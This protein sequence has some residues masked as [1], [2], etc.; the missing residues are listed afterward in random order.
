MAA[1]SCSYDVFLSFR[2]SDTRHGFVGNLYKALD[3]KG[4][5]TFIDDE[6][7]QRGE[8]ITP[9]LMKAIEESRIAITVLSHN[10]AS[11]SFCLDELVNIIACAKKKG[12]LVLPVFY[13]L[14]PSDVRHQKGSFAEALA[15]HEERFKDKKESFSHNMDR[16]EKWKMALHHVASFSGY[17]F[18]QGYEYEYEFIRRIVEFVS[19]KINRTPLHVADYPVGLEAQMVEVMKLL[20]VGSEDGVHMV[21]IHGIGGIGKT[22][23]ALAIYNMVVD[24]FDGLCF[25]ENV[26]E[27]SDRHG[28]QHLQSILLAELVKEKRINIA[29]VQEGISMIQHRLQRKKVLLIVDDVDKHEQLQ[30]IV[31]RCEWFGSGS[32]I[33]ITTRDEQILASHEVKRMYEVK[34]LNKKDSLQLLTW[35]AFGTDEADPSYKEVLN[36]VVA[37]ASGLPLALEV[38]G[39]N[40]FGKSI[41]EWKSAIKQYERIPNNQILKILK[42]SFDA[43]EEEEKSVFLDIACCFKGYELEEVQDILRAHY[44][45][46]MKYHIGVLVD[47][48][49]LKFSVHGVMVKMHDLVEDMGKEIVRKESPKDPGKRSRL[50]LHEDIIQVLEDNT[51]TSEI[52]IIHLDFPP[53]DKEE[54]VE[55]NRKAFKKM[56]NLKTLI[57]KSGNFSAGPKY[58]PNSLRVLEWWRYPSHD[59]PS[60]FH[61][62]KLAMCKLPQ[63]CFTSHELVRLLKKFMGMRFLNLDKSKSLTQIPDVSGLPNLEKLSF[64]HCQNLTAIHNSIGFL[65]KLK[66]LS[67]FG[68]T[69]LVRFPPIKLSA[70]EKLNL[71]RCHSLENFPEILGK[72]ENIRVLQLEYTAIKELPCSF[73]NFTRLQELQLSNCGVVQLPSSIAVMPELTDLIGWKWKGWQWLKEEEDE[74]KHGSC[75]VSSNVECLWASECNLCDDFFSIGFMRFAHVKDLDLSKNNFTVL[76]ECIK[77]FQFL[78]KLKVSDCKLLQEIRGIPPSLKHF[79]AKNCKSLTSSSTSMFLNQELHEDGKTEFYLP[80][81]RVPEWFDHKSNGPSISLWF[82]NRFPDKVVCLVIGAVNDSGMFRPMVVINGNKSFVGSGYFMMGMDHTYIFDLKTMEF[83]DDL[84]GVPLENEWNHAEVKYIGLEE[85]SILKESG[86][87]VFKQESGMEDIW[88][89]DPYGKRKLEDDLNS[90]ESQNQQLL[91][92]HRFVDM[93]AL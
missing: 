17:H 48:S 25:L 76:P 22:T 10:Y 63:S 89:S 66:I 14:N 53:L 4:I 29:S 51:G 26:R 70:L 27:N 6:K 54:I 2:G 79:L 80:G 15:R 91:K 71:S 13:D 65:C 62:K 16:L 61:S 49:L 32:R 90:L 1:I 77:E 59:L 68:C 44:G 46:C 35:K 30:A 92:K 93:E 87:H 18:K 37:Y 5:H 11:S 39:S 86:I 56:R 20:D 42:V 81:E 58:L 64:Q 41:E 24:H 36:R 73:Q 28:L 75:V 3:D 21:G 45:D 40:L 72:M 8:E 38:I 78:R 52:E 82:R 47:K 74:E 31:G 12:L 60:D 23:L 33:M 50:W 57:I 9:A 69:K 84:Y 55:W 85:T 7:L 88:F 43:L 34:E 83:E 19:S 67:A